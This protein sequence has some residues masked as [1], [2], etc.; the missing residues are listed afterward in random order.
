[1]NSK[2]TSPLFLLRRPTLHH[3][4]T[5]S[6]PFFNFSDLRPPLKKGLGGGGTGGRGGSPKYVYL[7]NFSSG[8]GITSL[9]FLMLVSTMLFATFPSSLLAV[10]ITRRLG[11]ILKFTIS[12]SCRLVSWNTFNYICKLY[13]NIFCFQTDTVLTLL[14][15]YDSISY[16]F[17]IRWLF[18][19]A[20][21]SCFIC[22]NKDFLRRL[23]LHHWKSLLEIIT[24]SS[25]LHA[26]KHCFQMIFFK[27][28]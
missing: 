3:T 22:E 19:F 13:S 6:T 9:A 15:Y 11:L 4:S 23:I 1:M 25:K 27:F 14:W 26:W 8:C 20:D 18:H 28:R 2:S 5:T 24:Y 7:I 12:A 17:F 21:I 10:F 16:E